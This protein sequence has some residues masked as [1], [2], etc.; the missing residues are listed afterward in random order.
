MIAAAVASVIFILI[1][2]IWIISAVM[3]AVKP[4][5]IT[6]STTASVSVS[7]LSKA[8]MI[9]NI[10]I[11]GLSK[12]QAKETIMKNYAWDMKATFE[13]KTEDNTYEVKNLIESRIDDILNEVYAG[14]PKETYT[15][16][17][18]NMDEAIKS[19][20]AVMAKKW[21]VAPKNGSISGF[22]K[23]SGSF[24]YDGEAS[25]TKIDEDALFNDIKTAIEQKNFKI[26]ISVKSQKVEAEITEAKAKE[27]YKVIGTFTTT[28]TSN[29][30]RNT[31]IGL[32]VKALD[33]LI[34]QPGVEFS[35]NNTTGNRTLERGYKP[36]G[37][38]LN[39][40]LVEEPGGGVCQV[41]STLY[42]AV[43]FSG[44]E[45]TERHAHSF[46][47]S[48]VTPGEDAMVSYDG[49]AG[50]DMKFVNSS[51]TAIA[52]RAKL[53]DQKL[54]VS[55]V[56]IPILKEGE[57]ISMTSKKM[58]EYESPQTVYE[59]DANMATGVEQTI[60]KGTK[61]SRWIT[62][63]VKKEGDK[64]ISDE[65]LH[66]STYKGKPTIIKRNSSGSSVKLGETSSAASSEESSVPVSTESA[67]G[68]HASA[69]SSKTGE[70]TKSSE[71]STSKSKESTK[72]KAKETTT[73]AE[74][75]AATQP[76]TT[77]E[78]EIIEAKPTS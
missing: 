21:N 46:E 4:K 57:K 16:D 74:T 5:K 9:D 65:F 12:V 49:Y 61:G 34:I 28:T 3:A 59:E 36:A 47:P 6:E 45:T 40:V 62:N 37:A 42:N 51:D 22:D 64:V 66:N 67:E 1:I 70:S 35:F 25:G 76:P 32:A 56:G 52:I 23:E 26:N 31:N 10:V 71:Q 17:L 41:S 44:L 50:P 29:V 72:A 18:S 73:A 39:G 8:V 33:G 69:A 2:I 55:I 24:I 7:E 58:S 19:E 38:Y 30:D 60:Q 14:T 53:V 75:T 54:T 43:V 48:Y 13:G 78:Q 15:I 27:M 11:T 20:I 77:Q 68:S 63:I